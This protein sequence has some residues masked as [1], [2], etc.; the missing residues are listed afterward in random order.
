MAIYSADGT[1]I[2]ESDTDIVLPNSEIL[3][4]MKRDHE[5]L[6]RMADAA[7]ADVKTALFQSEVN[8]NQ[9]KLAM[10]EAE[11]AKK[12][13]KESKR[14]SWASIAIAFGSLMVA[15]LTFVFR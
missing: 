7:K 12:N 6:R 13:A 8:L 9:L 11:E 3:T 10:Q 1:K 14:L 15:L 4:Q 5:E 2:G